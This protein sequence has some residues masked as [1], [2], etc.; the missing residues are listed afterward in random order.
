MLIC[1]E[2]KSFHPWIAPGLKYIKI[3]FKSDTLPLWGSLILPAF[4][5]LQEK[6]LKALY[7]WHWLVSW[8]WKKS[9][10][11]SEL[12]FIVHGVDRVL[13]RLPKVS[14]QLHRRRRRQHSARRLHQRLVYTHRFVSPLDLERCHEGK[15]SSGFHSMMAFM[16]SFEVFNG[17]AKQIR[18]MRKYQDAC[19]R[20]TK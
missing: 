3:L 2:Y 14:R 6:I 4:G 8:R 17:V 11:T 10:R 5:I 9:A 16:R 20:F 7:N 15:I 13:R 18:C 1:S 19:D 12:K